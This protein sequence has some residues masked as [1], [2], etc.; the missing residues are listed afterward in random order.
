MLLGTY[1]RDN[2]L[3]LFTPLLFAK[4]PLNISSE[5]TMKASPM[6]LALKENK[7]Q[8]MYN[9]LD[10]RDEL[11]TSPIHY[12]K[13]LNIGIVIKKDSKEIMEPVNKLKEYLLVITISA[14]FISI[15]ISFF[16]ASFISKI[17]NNIVRIICRIAGGNYDERIEVYGKDELSILSKFVNKMADSLVDVNIS[18]ENRVKNKT[19][20]LEKINN[21]LNNIFNITPSMILLSDGRTVI[22]GNQEF[23]KFTGYK[24]LDEFL[25]D[26]NCICDMFVIR[27]G[28]LRTKID[29]VNWA[30]YIL[31][32]PHMSHKA[33]IEK[34][35]V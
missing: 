31:K 5:N 17:I 32:N 26:Y 3:V 22:K 9:S 1:N 8:V 16:I 14:I 12:F 15:I 21:K 35:G 24:S 27:K 34:N 29:G 19:K 7:H 4:F 11:V 25:R 13:P 18:L 2:S 33:I 28:Y 30:D 6:R 10:Y 23:F 20:Q